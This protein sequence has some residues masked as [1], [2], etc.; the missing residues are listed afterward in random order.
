MRVLIVGCGYV[1]LPLATELGRQ[2]HEVVGL[3][4][5]EV[6]AAAL[7]AAR[8]EAVQG[9]IAEPGFERPPG[10]FDWV[11]FAAAAGRNGGE[12]EYRS[13]YVEGLG[14]VIEQFRGDPPKKFVYTGST[15]VYAQQ[16]GSVVKETSVAAPVA[17]EARVLV[18][19]ERLVLA[20]AKGG[21]PGVVLRLAGIYGPDRLNMMD[22][23]IRN[24]V[25]L[26][27]QGARYLNMIHRDD[28][29][30]AVLAA[31]RNGRAGEVYNVVDDEPVTEVTFYTW[32]AETLGKWTPPFAPE[33]DA[34]AG[35]GR[36][37]RR[38]SGR[39]LGMELGYRLR[40]PNFRQGYTAE[41]KRLTDAGLLDIQPEAR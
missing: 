38:I 23:L 39:R 8:I 9:D 22:R 19:A 28:V 34:A 11:V 24:E 37:N 20:A 27:G 36:P 12:A 29:V 18:E 5:S 3:R 2:G 26:G 15:S 31:L 40:Y 13:V 32:L 6:G 21:V 35:A 33:N 4:R 14:R 25:K 41:V 17:A 30:G 7:R 16:D 1:G 10:R